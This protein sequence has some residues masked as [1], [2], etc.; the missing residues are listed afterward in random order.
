[1]TFIRNV[2]DEGTLSMRGDRV[3]SVEFSINCYR[4]TRGMMAEGS[5]TLADGTFPLGQTGKI[6]LQ[7]G[8]SFEVVAVGGGPQEFSIK[9][10]GPFYGFRS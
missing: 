10:S 5:M 7:S 4:V 1:M 9:V 2:S 3:G 8:Q 6:T